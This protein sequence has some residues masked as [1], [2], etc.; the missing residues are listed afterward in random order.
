MKSYNEEFSGQMH[1]TD[2]YQ[3][4]PIHFHTFTCRRYVCLLFLASTKHFLWRRKHQ[5]H[6]ARQQ[7]GCWRLAYQTLTTVYWS[8]AADT[9]RLGT[10]RLFAVSAHTGT[11]DHSRPHDITCTK[12]TTWKLA[13]SCLLS[14]GY[15]EAS[16]RHLWKR[17]PT[18]GIYTQHFKA[19]SDRHDNKS[20]WLEYL[21]HYLE[22]Q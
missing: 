7:T 22:V 14:M 10:N 21:L 4:I 5:K 16:S 1:M 8:T 17:L 18:S 13:C 9:D 6:G 2:Y 11:D 12:G 19:L 3:M 20:L 15:T